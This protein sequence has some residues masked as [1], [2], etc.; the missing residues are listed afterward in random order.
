MDPILSVP[1]MRSALRDAGVPIVAVCPLIA[2]RAV[3]GPTAKIMAELGLEATPRSIAMHYA[4]IADG[5]VIDAADASWADRCSMPTYVTPT[6]MR[7]L[8]DRMRLADETV[9]FAAT[10]RASAAD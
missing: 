2:G 8:E 9:A 4:G 6:L 3:K 7:S 5:L 10:L 1:G